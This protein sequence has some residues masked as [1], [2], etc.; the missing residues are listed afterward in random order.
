MSDFMLEMLV[1]RASASPVSQPSQ[2]WPMQWGGS[3]LAEFQGMAAWD[4]WKVGP[5]YLIMILNAIINI[6]CCP[7][8][9][10]P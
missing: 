8:G 4:L 9:N 5:L 7:I 10:W 1:R 2:H 6:T 3:T